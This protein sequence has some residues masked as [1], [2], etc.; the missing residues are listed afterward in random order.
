MEDD[1]P[2]VAAFDPIKPSLIGSTNLSS[3]LIA[4]ASKEGGTETLQVTSSHVSRD[5][6]G[7]KEARPALA[8]TGSL[9]L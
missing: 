7:G 6:V 8:P 4:M 5:T 3:N 1:H 2:G 9:R